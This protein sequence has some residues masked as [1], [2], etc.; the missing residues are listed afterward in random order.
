MSI[1]KNEKVLGIEKDPWLSKL[2]FRGWEG[3][4]QRG[5][6][7]PGRGTYAG[8]SFSA[9]T[10]TLHTR[11][12]EHIT[13]TE[14]QNGRLRN[15]VVKKK[16]NNLIVLEARGN[17]ASQIP[18]LSA[19]LVPVFPLTVRDIIILPVVEAGDLEGIHDTSFSQSLTSSPSSGIASFVWPSPYPSLNSRYSYLFPGLQLYVLSSLLGVLAILLSHCSQDDLRLVIR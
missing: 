14:L 18:P 12:Y 10:S 16:W 6:Y 5:R 7:I 8:S 9:S 13:D 2:D 1:K 11:C 17:V 4:S 15:L 3:I 19:G